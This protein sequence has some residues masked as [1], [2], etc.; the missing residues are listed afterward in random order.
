MAQQ[1]SLEDRLV[2]LIGGGGFF[3]THLA[4]EL[5]RRGARLRIADRHP[6]KAIHLRPLANLGQIQF[7]RCNVTDR[8]SVEAAISGAH[9]VAYLVGTFG[10]DQKALQAEGAGMAAQAAAAAGA[11]AFLYVSALGADAASDSAYARTKGEGEELVRAAFPRATVLRPSIM[12][13]EDDNFIN[14]FAG[15]VSGLPAVPVFGGDAPLQPVWV[16]DAAQA[17]AIALADP[18]RRGGKTYELA[19]PEVLTMRELHE[20]IAHAQG[21]ERRFIAVPDG[22]SALFAKLPGTPMNTDQ[23]RLLRGGNVATGTLPGF[24]Q[25]DIAPRPLGLFLDR[26]MT[27]FRRHGRFTQAGEAA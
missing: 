19:G 27:R 4:Q 24:R 16:D 17:A 5:L 26:W 12:F 25:L 2:T 23:W 1:G 8:R 11:H 15:L 18:A 9:A 10:A 21:R 7:A 22:L 3:G 6:E 14:L 20:R 13:G